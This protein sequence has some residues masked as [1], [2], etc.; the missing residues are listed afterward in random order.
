MPSPDLWSLEDCQYAYV[1]IMF[2]IY[3]FDFL[4]A[5]E[6]L[7]MLAVGKVEPENIDPG[8]V[9]ISSI[10]FSSSQA[11]PQVATILVLLILMFI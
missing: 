3:F 2:S 7:V 8:L 10:T 9:I 11:G 6:M 4:K 1:N 5:F